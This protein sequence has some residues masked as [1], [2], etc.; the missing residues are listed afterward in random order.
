[1]NCP[2]CQT[3]NPAQAIFCLNCGFKFQFDAPPVDPQQTN[4]KYG[5]AMTSL[6]AT[7]LNRY[8]QYYCSDHLTSSLLSKLR[9]SG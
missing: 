1:M 2:R 6:I 4:L 5:L 3:V 9:H 8:F 7:L